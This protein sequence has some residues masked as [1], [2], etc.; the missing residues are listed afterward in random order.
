MHGGIVMALCTSVSQLFF[1]VRSCR[2]SSEGFYRIPSH[3][4]RNSVVLSLCSITIFEFF[5]A[6]GIADF[7]SHLLV[8][9]V[10]NEEDTHKAISV[11]AKAM[12]TRS[13]GENRHWNEVI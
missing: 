3:S 9:T 10:D 6:V 13:D 8:I 2:I 4:R 1:N 12:T 5:I 7:Q 11:P